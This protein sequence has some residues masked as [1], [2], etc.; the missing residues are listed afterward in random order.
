MPSTQRTQPEPGL[1][2]TTGLL[3]VASHSITQKRRAAW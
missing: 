3:D 1:A 2:A